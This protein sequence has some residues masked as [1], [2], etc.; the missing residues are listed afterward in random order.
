MPGVVSMCRGPGDR[1]TLGPHYCPPPAPTTHTHAGL[2]PEN[3]NGEFIENYIQL[4]Q[5]LP[6]AVVWAG[7]SH[8]SGRISVPDG[9]DRGWG[10]DPD[11][12]GKLDYQTPHGTSSVNLLNGLSVVGRGKAWIGDL[13][14]ATWAQ[15]ARA[16]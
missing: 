12:L 9:R 14:S 2:Q 5:P 6:Q 1:T 11:S 7:P 10:Q 15:E 8:T 4:V 16:N 3:R 13:Y